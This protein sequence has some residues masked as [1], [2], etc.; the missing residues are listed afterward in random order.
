MIGRGSQSHEPAAVPLPSTTFA[1]QPGQRAPIAWLPPAPGRPVT[2]GGDAAAGCTIPM[3]PA[4]V[5]IGS[6]CMNGPI[7]TTSTTPEG[8]LIITQDV[9]KIGL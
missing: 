5:V 7:V 3:Q 2:A 1:V 4:H 6:L 8:A 9:R